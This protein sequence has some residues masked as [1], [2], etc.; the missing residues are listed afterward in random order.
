MMDTSSDRIVITGLGMVTPCGIG[1]EQTWDNV[2][3]GRSGIGTISSFDASDLAVRIAGEVHDWDPLAYIPKKKLRESGRFT[4]FAV[5]AAHLAVR[6][7]GL[8][9]SEEQ[10]EDAACVM[11]VGMGGL[12]GIE[13][14]SELVQAKR[15]SKVSPYA[16][17][18][19][20]LNMAAG[21]ITMAL[22]F[23]GPSY[24]VSSA[25][26]SGAHAISD[27]LLLLRSRQTSIVLAGGA[28]ATITPTCIAG[29]QAMFAL[30]RRND[31]PQGACRPF[32]KNRDGFVASEGATVL[33]L[34]RLEDARKRR[35]KIYAEIT[36]YGSSSDA[37]HAVQPAPEG[38][39]AVSAMRRAV[40]SAK[41]SLSDVDYVNA[42]GTGTPQGDVQESNALCLLFGEHASNKGLWVSSTKSSLGHL[43]GAA[44][45]AEAALAALS[46]AR[47]VIPPTINMQEQDPACAIE[48]VAN[49]ARERR[50]RHALSNSFGFGGTNACLLV[51][52]FE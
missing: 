8:E 19:I 13:R 24:C 21:Q 26:A 4:Q 48:I 14:V 6:D 17:P 47:G 5:G 49:E 9:L 12:E 7:A 37:Y 50:V 31:D 10:R 52:R 11:G 23:R 2:V 1:W 18:T 16:I 46:C 51:S 25:C 35:A 3:A 42:H 39:G 27:A 43:L 29:F 30:S 33:V 22:G 45:A 36:G 40:Q 34:E 28:E 20:S 32:E 15:A 44:G 38:R 41:V